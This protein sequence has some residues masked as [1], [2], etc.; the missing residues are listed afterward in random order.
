MESQF[1]RILTDS[2]EKRAPTL[3][4]GVWGV[5]LGSELSAFI[6]ITEGRSGAE[7]A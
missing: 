7:V 4:V 6:A 3:G 2:L 1:L 5:A